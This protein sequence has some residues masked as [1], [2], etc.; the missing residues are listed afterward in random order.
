METWL[1]ITILQCPSCG[2][3]YAEASWYVVEMESNIECGEC[4]KEF[5]SKKSAKDRAILE[6]QI[7]D[8]GRIQKVRVA[9]RLKL[10]NK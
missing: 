7:D 4:R 5:N 6:L 3:Y 1:D 8:I 10:K 2:R 9:R